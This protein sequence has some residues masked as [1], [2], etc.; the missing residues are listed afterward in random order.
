MDINNTTEVSKVVNE[1]V[2]SKKVIDTMDSVIKDAK[3]KELKNIVSELV[4]K[5]EVALGKENDLTKLAKIKSEYDSLVY[6][7]LS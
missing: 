3:L 7:K 2:D 1:I 5:Y 6:D 4:K